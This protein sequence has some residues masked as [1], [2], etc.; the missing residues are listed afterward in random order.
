MV[1]TFKV[2]ENL[3]KGLHFFDGVRKT[4][5]ASQEFDVIEQRIGKVLVKCPISSPDD[6][7]MVVDLAQKALPEWAKQ[8]PLER[9]KVLRAAANITRQNLKAIAVWETRTNG[10]PIREALLDIEQAADMLD[11]YAGIAPQV[12]LG[13]CFDLTGERHAYTKREPYGVIGA[14]GAWNYPFLTAMWKVAPAL[15]AGNAIVYKPS[16]FSA[17]S[18]VIIGEILAA[19]GLPTNIFCVV[20]GEASTGEALCTNK[21]IRKVSFTGSVPTGKKIQHLCSVNNVKPVTLELGG[22]SALIICEDADLDNAVAGAMMANFYNQGQVCCNATRVF[23]HSSI[24]KEFE[25]RL[26]KEVNRVIKVGD[27][28]AEETRVGAS[29][30]EGHLKKV[31]GFVESAKE[32]GATILAGGERVYPEGAKEG[33]YM[34]PAVITNVTDSMTVAREE[35]FGACLL[36]I[37]FDSEEEAIERANNTEFGLAS[38]IFSKDL[39]KCHLI[40]RQLQAGTVWINTYNDC[41]VNVPFGGYKNSGVGRENC[42]SALL[43]FSQEKSVYVNL[44][45]KL[46]HGF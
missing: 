8:T 15:A 33:Y 1:G 29:I 44:G 38:G 27:P 14:I 18:P 37:P 39:A 6:V 41:E 19:A 46:D 11:Y 23:V 30:N 26:V 9:A 3:D 31:M 7:N 25:E 10:K 32:E 24:K 28:L 21:L 35:I 20:Q 16:P 45:K 12:L 4:I 22:K 42:H 5:A 40:A 34:Q 2:I 43:A 13:D 36:V 17:C